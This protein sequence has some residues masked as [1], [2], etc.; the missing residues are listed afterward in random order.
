MG[1]ACVLLAVRVVATVVFYFGERIDMNPVNGSMAV[2]VGL[3]LVPEVL[4]ACVLLG[5]GVAARN[6]KGAGVGEVEEGQK[7]PIGSRGS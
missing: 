7:V 4:A 3:Y 5:G 6:V 1:G 2:R